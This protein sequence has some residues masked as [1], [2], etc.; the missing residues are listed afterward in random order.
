[1]T[2]LSLEQLVRIETAYSQASTVLQESI[3][4]GASQQTIFE[5][6]ACVGMLRTLLTRNLEKK[7]HAH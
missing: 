5:L 7:H 3:A 6:S 1:M 2:E 4:N